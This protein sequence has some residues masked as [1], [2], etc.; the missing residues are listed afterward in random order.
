RQQPHQGARRE[1]GTRRRHSHPPDLRHEDPPHHGQGRRVA[2][3]HREHAEVSALVLPGFANVHSHAFQRLL[4]GDVQRR[5][6]ARTDDSFWT[7]R[8]AMY[9]LALTLDL[10][11]L[12]AA[13]RLCYA[14]CL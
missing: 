13:A 2:D 3:P 12:R 6:P 4:R 1:G 7:W 11:D 9:A 5:G 8:E 10:D 14:E